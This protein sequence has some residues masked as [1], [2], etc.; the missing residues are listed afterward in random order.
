MALPPVTA[1]RKGKSTANTTKGKQKKHYHEISSKEGELDDEEE[2][3]EEDEV[4]SS[5]AGS[6]ESQ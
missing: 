6:G 2:D 3:K 1:G 5:M 4:T